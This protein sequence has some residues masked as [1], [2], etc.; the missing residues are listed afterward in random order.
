MFYLFLLFQ[1]TGPKIDYQ[2]QAHVAPRK[3]L[4]ETNGNVPSNGASNGDVTKKNLI[5]AKINKWGGAEVCP[6][7]NKS[8]FIA[9]LMRG[10]GKAWHKSCFTCLECKKRLDSSMLCEREG[11]VYCK[12]KYTNVNSWYLF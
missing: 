10:A 11:E 4:S 7:C 1:S 6:R 9:E 12:C 8:V 2:A 5:N 3:T